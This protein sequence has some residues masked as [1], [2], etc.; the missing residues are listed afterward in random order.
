M[1]CQRFVAKPENDEEEAEGEKKKIKQKFCTKYEK[2]LLKK[3]SAQQC[4]KENLYG[5]FE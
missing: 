4:V 1:K 2:K 3:G 5:K